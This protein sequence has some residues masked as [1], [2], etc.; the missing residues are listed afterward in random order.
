MVI[1]RFFNRFLAYTDMNTNAT[2]QPRRATFQ[3]IGI[4]L[5]DLEARPTILI[6]FCGQRFL[7]FIFSCPSCGQKVG[8]WVHFQ[9]KSTTR[10]PPC[11]LGVFACFWRSRP[12][13]LSPEWM[14]RLRSQTLC[15][16]RSL[17]NIMRCFEE[18]EVLN[19]RVVEYWTRPSS[20]WKW[21]HP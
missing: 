8:F 5:F 2:G 15:L 4:L 11:V 12:M 19:Q 20:L 18:F 9:Q 21:C 6:F 7:V 3:K 10:G 14:E 17:K 1:F 13:F 16:T